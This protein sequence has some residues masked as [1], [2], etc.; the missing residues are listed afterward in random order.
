VNVSVVRKRWRAPPARRLVTLA[1][2]T[3]LGAAIGAQAEVPAH[4]TQ[5]YDNVEYNG[6]FTF[7]RVR[8]G[9]GGFG[10]GGGSA[11]AHDYPQ[12][13]INLPAVLSEISSIRPNLGRSNVL[14]LEDDAIFHNPILYISEP[15]FWTISE[16]GVRNLREYLLKGG[17]LIADDFEADQWNNFA[18]CF[19]LAM[20]EFE[21][22]KLDESH[23]IFRS[24]F[25]IDKLDTPHP[26]VRVEPNYYGVFENNDPSGRMIAIINHNND[27]AEYW[28][29]SGTGFFAM[30]PTNGAFKLGINYVVYALTH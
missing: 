23:P 2:L 22:I 6:R 28:E 13:D 3:V 21:F 24:F 17:F 11:W 7:S 14:D 26:L 16:R 27:L 18:Y 12:A 1:A 4:A 20:P 8:Y 15:G 25:G 30:D 9:G 29:H 19:K 10:R 5:G